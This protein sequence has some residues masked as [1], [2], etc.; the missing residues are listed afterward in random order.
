MTIEQ[1]QWSRRLD[2]EGCVNARDLG[3]YGT[4]DGGETYPLRGRGKDRIPSVE[5]AVAA[6]P[7]TPILFHFKGSDPSEAD[8]LAAVE[9]G[10]GAPEGE[11]LLG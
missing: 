5:E 8:L 10:R 3:G 11:P 4:A 9:L 1:R 7:N 6:L 2:W